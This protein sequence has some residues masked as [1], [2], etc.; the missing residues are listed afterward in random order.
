MQLVAGANEASLGTARG[1]S[2]LLPFLPALLLPSRPTHIQSL[3]RSGPLPG[4]LSTCFL[5]EV[6][7]HPESEFPAHLLQ[8]FVLTGLVTEPGLG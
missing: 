6:R 4:P 7:S 2:R 8:S 5:L 1:Y 3:S